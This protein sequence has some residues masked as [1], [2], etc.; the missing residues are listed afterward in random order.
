MAQELMRLEQVTR[1]IT[2]EFYIRKI[3]LTINKGEVFALAGKNAAGKSTLASVM[4]GYLPADSGRIYFEGQQVQLPDPGA[5]LKLGIIT[6]MQ[7]NQGFE[8]MPVADNVLFGNDKYYKTGKMSPRK[9]AAVCAECFEKLGIAIDPRAPFYTLTPAQ[10]QAVAIARAYLFDAK[11]IIMDEPS[12]R[13]PQKECEVL[14]STVRALRE[15]GVSILYITHRLDEII[16]LADRVAFIERGELKEVRSTADMTEL[17]LIEAIEGFRVDNIYSK[18][19]LE[20]GEPVLK[21]Q[22][23]SAGQAK[24]INFTLHKSEVIALVS[25]LGMCA[26]SIYRTLNGLLQYNGSIQ[27]D[28]KEVKIDNPLTANSLRIVSA[29]DEDMEETLSNYDS[30]DGRAVGRFAVLSARFRDTING[31]GK[32]LNNVVG[33]KLQQ[34][35]YMTGGYRQKELVLRTLAKDGDIYILVDP[36]NGIDLQTKMRVY[37]DIAQ[38]AKHG[39]GILYFTNDVH[40]AV[41]LADRILVLGTNTIVFDKNA[42]ETDAS[43]LAK[44]LKE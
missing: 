23:L 20:L 16:K 5:A 3:N 10:K 37:S 40:E 30:K 18:E 31:V 6:L 7:N 19:P 22:N 44:L 41:G 43:T 26:Q 34:K 32:M 9:L 33:L 13:L 14:Y 4:N 8:Q 2:S 39:K 24:D 28:G 12:S 17:D 35:E 42:K 29:I 27:V 36:T 25:D 21:V 15:N 1:R 38:L 11:L